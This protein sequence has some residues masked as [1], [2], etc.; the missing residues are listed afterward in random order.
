MRFPRAAV[1]LTLASGLLLAGCAE[2]HVGFTPTGP[3]HLGQSDG[4]TWPVRATVWPTFDT[5]GEPRIAEYL[6][7]N[8]ATKQ[9]KICVSVPSVAVDYF[10]NIA[11]GAKTQAGGE[12]VV[13]KTVAGTPSTT[14]MQQAALTKTCA[15]QSDAL[16]LAPVLDADASTAYRSLLAS[17]KAADK[18]VVVASPGLNA[19]G[20]IA[21]VS[22]VPR[23][24][25][26]QLGYW[27]NADADG[28]TGQLIVVAGPK[29]SPQG[30]ALVSGLLSALPGSTLTVAGIYY[31]PLTIEGQRALVLRAVR[32]HPSAKYIVGIARSIATAFKFVKA[33]QA[34]DSHVLASLTYDMTINAMI[35]NGQ[36]AVAIDDRAVAQGA[37]ALDQAVR[38]LQGQSLPAVEAP[39]A[40]LMDR[41]SITY[42]DQT[43]SIAS[44]VEGANP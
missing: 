26:Q 31:G 11:F 29:D 27:L 39:A 9:W 20:V 32:E 25:S 16:V 24:A 41:T 43:G 37:M 5:S 35:S 13:V 1:A 40:Q 34:A 14:S 18:P 21:S 22:P 38:I 33:G 44:A 10:S 42:L 2:N 17:E 19:I 8:K 28:K 15:E 12:R 36:V 3:P 30:A 4:I 6:P 7:L 23:L